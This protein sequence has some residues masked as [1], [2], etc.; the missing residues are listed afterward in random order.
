[1]EQNNFPQRIEF[2]EQSPLLCTRKR[3]KY[4]KH[5]NLAKK[6]FGLA[7]RLLDPTLR[8]VCASMRFEIEFSVPHRNLSSSS[9]A[10]LRFFMQNLAEIPCFYIVCGGHSFTLRCAA[11]SF[12]LHRIG[13]TTTIAPT[14]GLQICS[15][16]T[17]VLTL[18]VCVCEL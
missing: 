7:I 9:S 2:D 11:R 10:C 13:S 4:R 15:R 12:N 17:S 16:A 8:C 3:R 14:I 6:L 5:F 18:D 1:M